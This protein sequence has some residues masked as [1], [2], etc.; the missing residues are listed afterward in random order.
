MTTT[1]TTT[2]TTTVNTAAAATAGG[3]DAANFENL[4]AS[5]NE[6]DRLR[7]VALKSPNDEAALTAYVNARDAAHAAARAAGLTPTVARAAAGAAA[8]VLSAARGRLHTAWT[9]AVS[10][11]GWPGAS[12]PRA[13]HPQLK[14]AHEAAIKEFDAT[15]ASWA[16]VAIMAEYLRG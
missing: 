7:D 2:T 8:E 1:T 4:V 16:R 15:K 9:D 10:A 5:F 11:A 6:V 12:P 3:I 13:D 14:V